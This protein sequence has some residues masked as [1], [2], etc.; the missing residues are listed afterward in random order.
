[1]GD[2]L[3]HLTGDAKEFYKIIN[4]ENNNVNKKV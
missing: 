2:G 1:M 3:Y 4:S